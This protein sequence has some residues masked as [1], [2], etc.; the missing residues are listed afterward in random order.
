MTTYGKILR[1]DHQL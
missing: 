1:H